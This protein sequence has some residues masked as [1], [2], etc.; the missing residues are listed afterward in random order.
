MK[1][2]LQK[3]DFVLPGGIGLAKWADGEVREITEMTSNSDGSVTLSFAP[4]EN[5]PEVTEEAECEIIAPKQ[6]T[7]S[8]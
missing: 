5:L 2:E 7:Q 1:N 6:I 4:I 8:K 3:N